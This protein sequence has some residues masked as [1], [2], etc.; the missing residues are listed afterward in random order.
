VACAPVSY[1]R[2]RPLRYDPDAR[3]IE[4]ER[5]RWVYER[6]SS[7]NDLTVAMTAD[8]DREYAVHRKAYE[9]TGDLT[10]LAIAL[11]YVR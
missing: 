10:E 3:A 7:V 5:Q 1:F 6:L 9:D 4:Q 2:G 8:P 11:A